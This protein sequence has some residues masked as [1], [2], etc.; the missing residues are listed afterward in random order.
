M[1]AKAI[2]IACAPARR[3]GAPLPASVNGGFAV[4]RVPTGGAGG[5]GSDALP[6]PNVMR[7]ASSRDVI[8]TEVNR[9]DGSVALW[10]STAHAVPC[11]EADAPGRVVGLV[12]CAG[13][14]LRGAVSVGVAAA[15][16][17]A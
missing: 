10:A 12:E 11:A 4:L 7:S 16:A 2:W 3:I 15:V 8:V 6:K 9:S 13:D 1:F 5:P 17:V 14:G